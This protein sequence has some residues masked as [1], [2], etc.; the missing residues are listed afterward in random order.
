MSA[1]A[2]HD[3]CPGPG[4]AS[5][6]V[7]PPL[8]ADADCLWEV[9]HLMQKLPGLSGVEAWGHSLLAG[10]VALTGGDGAALYHWQ[11]QELHVL[12]LNRGRLVL[13]EPD[14]PQVARVAREHD[15]NVITRDPAATLSGAGGGGVS[16]QD[17]AFPL[18]VGSRLRGVVKVTAAR[19]SLEGWRLPLSVLFNHVALILDHAAHEHARIK[20]QGDLRRW[21]QVFAHA[22]WGV[23]L[24]SED[25]SRLELVNPAFAR[26]HGY[27]KEELSGHPL[28]DMMAPSARSAF[29]GILKEIRE[30]GH[31][32]WESLHQRRSGST[33]PALLDAALVR[34][35][36]GVSH[37]LVVNV[38]DVSPYHHARDALRQVAQ[39]WT[40]AM[41]AFD[42]GVA[43]LSPSGQ[44]L[45]ANQAFLQWLTH[46]GGTAD[47]M[48]LAA[49]FRPGRHGDHCPLC[50][51]VQSGRDATVVLEAGS[52]HNP[53]AFPVELRLRRLGRVPGVPASLLVTLRDLSAAR[54]A[55]M[56]LKDAAARY[57]RLF[58]DSPTSLWEEDFSAVRIHLEQRARQQGQDAVTLLRND[59]DLAREC[60]LLVRVVEVNHASAALYE[61]GDCQSLLGQLDR[62][63]TPDSLGPFRE[64]LMAFLEGRPVYEC[65]AVQQT[66][67]GCRLWTQVRA[68]LLPGHENTWDRVLVSVVDLS[69]RRQME[70]SLLKAKEAAEGANR[71]QNEFLA[72][73]SHEMRTPLHVILGMV[74]LLSDSS[75]TRAQAD[76]LQTLHRSGSTLLALINDLLELS[77]ID[78][79]GLALT[80][81]GFDVREW[82]E[83]TLSVYHAAAMGK[84]LRLTLKV[85]GGVPQRIRGDA[86]RLRQVLLNLV[87]NAVKFTP[88]G[89]VQVQ[90]TCAPG[91]GL[92]F[93]V[94]DTGPG[95]PAELHHAIFQ[96]FRQGWAFSTREH[97]GTGLGLALSRKLVACMGGQIHLDSVPGQGSR[98]WFTLDL[99]G[100][101]REPPPQ[102]PPVAVALC[103]PQ[104]QTPRVLNILLVDDSED[105]RLLVQAFL[106]RTPH[107]LVPAVNGQEALERFC[108]GNFDLVLMD[109]Q[110]PVMD[111]CEA[112]RRI[113]QWEQEQGRVPTPIVA[114]TAH[115]MSAE[116]AGI[117]AAG[118][119]RHLSKPVGR[120]GMLAL[121]AEFAAR[122][123]G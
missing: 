12:D 103:P 45:R 10:L 112:T 32:T 96:P 27:L 15:V 40:Q 36:D 114:L 84:G 47:G 78:A 116:A 102:S 72:T 50:R 4:A 28:R 109:I 21:E 86:A 13:T 93:L 115:A 8:P 101:H 83:E 113:R 118:C 46:S 97:G 44:L 74:D 23:V 42:D 55:E 64:E 68:T 120:E 58:E 43:L 81:T 56:I 2:T 48:V 11:G 19:R 100:E 9:F 37:H 76:N 66:L 30:H 123:G 60:A 16:C 38:Q 57:R 1:E 106:R 5:P 39:E 75:L 53:V 91:G 111:G 94:T 122:P 77:R 95:I 65:E 85:E 20:T 33:F 88:R 107:R 31:A 80:T 17:W 26:M 105:N 18:L 24:C 71:L 73:I 104:G 54:A 29:S 34:N 119:D 22:E 99:P 92:M 89:S 51:A 62:V 82:M 59:P 117:L 6:G 41:D 63:F 61:A 3:G 108:S 25:G 87:G 52:P 49:V 35:D 110:M 121:V 79:E 7:S 14:D 67:T 69:A 90:L 70:E 98:F